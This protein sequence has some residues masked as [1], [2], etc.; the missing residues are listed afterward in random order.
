MPAR[1]Q[2]ERGPQC[3]WWCGLF[4]DVGRRAGRLRLAVRVL[5]ISAYVAALEAALAVVAACSDKPISVTD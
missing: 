1:R 2:D 4:S 5:T 3:L